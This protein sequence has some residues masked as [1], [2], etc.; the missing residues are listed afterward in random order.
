MFFIIKWMKFIGATLLSE[1]NAFVRGVETLLSI[2]M[3][4]LRCVS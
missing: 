2:K 1:I 3:H 4:V